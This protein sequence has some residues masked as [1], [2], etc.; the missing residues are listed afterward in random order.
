MTFDEYA[1]KYLSALTGE[2]KKLVQMGWNGCQEF[3]N[4]EA[5]QP[6]PDWAHRLNACKHHGDDHEACAV[7]GGRVP[8]DVESEGGEAL[9]FTTALKIS[10]AVFAAY[11]QE[12]PKWG[13]KLDGTP[14]QNDLPVRVAKAFQGFYLQPK[15]ADAPNGW[16]LVPINPTGKMLG[17]IK[18]P[19]DGY[20]NGELLSRYHEMLE[21]APQPPA[22]GG[23]GDE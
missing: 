1:E 10:K 19:I 14:T 12:F 5:S 15:P 13:K 20:H 8:C 11:R 6:D 22:H 17:V 18:H 3:G 9:G 23:Q 2:A 4:K 7:Y 21:A 16:Q